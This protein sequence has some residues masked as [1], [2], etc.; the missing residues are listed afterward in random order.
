MFFR[1]AIVVIWGYVGWCIGFKM[2]TEKC[3]DVCAQTCLKKLE[4]TL[5]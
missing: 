3:A 4:G 5:K 2:G 1:V